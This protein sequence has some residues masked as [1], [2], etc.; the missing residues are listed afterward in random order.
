MNPSSRHSAGSQ[1]AA[2]LL[3][4]VLCCVVLAGCLVIPVDYHAT[5]SR[6][7]ITPQS[8]NTLRIGMTTREDV[9]LALGEPDFVSEDGRRF[10]YL[11]TKVKAI[12]AVASYG[13][14]GTGG[15][16]TRSYLIETSFDPSNRVSDVRLLKEW[17]D[18]V[19]GTPEIDASR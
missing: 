4:A 6:H 9:L 13:G 17:G 18:S 16:I 14:S 10:G 12:W 15:E 19:V 2:P 5:G 7:N 8:T 11:W 1:I 3:A